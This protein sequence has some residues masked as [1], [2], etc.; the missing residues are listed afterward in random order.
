M[1]TTEFIKEAVCE[2]CN[3]SKC[4][5]KKSSYIA[6][7]LLHRDLQLILSHRVRYILGE[8]SDKLELAYFFVCRP[9]IAIKVEGLFIFL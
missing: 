3:G 1:K 9:H 8:K 4:N 7:E 6:K 5:F 2:S